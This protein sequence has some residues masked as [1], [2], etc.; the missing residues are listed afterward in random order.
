MVGRG[1]GG[2]AGKARDCGAG[3]SGKLSASHVCVG[4]SL[5]PEKWKLASQRSKQATS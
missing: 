3:M 2:G 1:A 4:E 5:K